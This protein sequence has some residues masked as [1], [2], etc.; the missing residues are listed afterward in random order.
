MMFKSLADHETADVR[1]I[2]L[3]KS[4]KNVLKLAIKLKVL[5]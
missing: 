1:V 3:P 2:I 5:F 4:E